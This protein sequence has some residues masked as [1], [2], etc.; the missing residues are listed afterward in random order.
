MMRTVRR[1]A[2]GLLAVPLLLGSCEPQCAPAPPAAGRVTEQRDIGTSVDGRPITAYRLGTPGGTPVLAV[3]S[4][5]GDE[6]AG[7][8]IVEHLRDAAAI[9]DGLDVWLVP[10]M[11]PD[12]NANGLRT[13]GRG[14]DLNRN[15]STN[16]APVDCAALPRNC[17]GPEPFSEPESK[18]FADF[19]VAIQPQ[20]TI[21]YHGADHVVSAATAIVARPDAVLAYARVSGYPLGSI[22]C[23]PACTGTATQFANANVAPS[24]AFTVELSTKAAGGMSPAGVTSHTAA[25]FAAAAAL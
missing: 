8:E 15:L 22:P 13:N 21:M 2:G 6:Q 24:T 4:I 9:P 1:F 7:I 16:W 19:V 17:A 12:G 18:A 20:L 14:V 5:H 11:N 10:T 3:G 25:F 23:S